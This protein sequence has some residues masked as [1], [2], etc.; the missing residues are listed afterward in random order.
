MKT[1]ISALNAANAGRYNDL[2]I[3]YPG[4]MLEPPVVDINKLVTVIQS[5]Y[6][7]QVLQY[8]LGATKKEESAASNYSNCSKQG[9]QQ[10][11]FV[12]T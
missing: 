9:Y 3:K 12:P 7:V 5:I 11:R 1:V 4:F 6:P 10:C 2:R 8:S